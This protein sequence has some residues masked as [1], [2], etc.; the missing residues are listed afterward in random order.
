MT[1]MGDAVDARFVSAAI[2]AISGQ[3]RTVPEDFVVEEVL[4]YEPCGVGTH[5]YIK[6]RKTGL[7]TIEAVKR[8]A[9]ALARREDEFGY[10]LDGST[11]FISTKADLIQRWPEI[12]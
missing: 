8:L 4:A 1:G 6:L 5:C 9:R 11:I 7:T 12:P 2:S 3:L 10:A